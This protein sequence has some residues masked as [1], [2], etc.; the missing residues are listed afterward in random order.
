MTW[1]PSWTA[2]RRE[3]ALRIL[4]GCLAHFR[5]LDSMVE[6]I[7]H[8]MRERIL[9]GLEQ[10]LVELGLLAFHLQA[11]AAAQR[12]HRSR[13][14]R[15]I[16]EKTFETGCMRAFITDSRRSAVTMSRRRE[17]SVM[18]GSAAVACRTWLRVSTSSPT[19]FIM[20]FSRATSTRNVLSAALPMAGRAAFVNRRAGTGLADGRWL[21]RRCSGL[22]H[23]DGDGEP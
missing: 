19:R 7:A 6:R 2:R 11:Y 9:D 12:L 8:G 15:G 16:F 23:R 17:S 4:A 20:R 3:Q 18:L 10:A 21:C 13:T 14:R 22:R 5:Q 1:L